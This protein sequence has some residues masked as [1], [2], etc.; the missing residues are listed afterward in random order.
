MSLTH[1]CDDRILRLETG[2]RACA[3]EAQAIHHDGALSI[4]RSPVKHGRI[5]H[6]AVLEGRPI[7]YCAGNDELHAS[8]RRFVI[9]A[10]FVRPEHRRRGIATTLYRAIIDTGTTLVSDWD[11]SEGA[12]RLWASLMRKEPMRDII[13]FQDGYVARRRTRDQ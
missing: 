10:T 9:D 13:H 12:H 8:G 3:H 1:A 7:A 6:Y 11:L 4:V 5:T 2:H